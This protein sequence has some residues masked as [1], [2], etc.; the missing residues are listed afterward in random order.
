MT[1]P[2]RRMGGSCG[3]PLVPPQII[4]DIAQVR[5]YGCEKYGDPD[6][7]RRVEKGRYLDA[8]L[9]HTLAYL[10]DPKG[11]DTES[12]LPHYKHMA[13][14]MAFLCEMEKEET[15]MASCKI[16]GNKEP[17]MYCVC[18]GCMDKLRPQWISVKERLPE[19]G[20]PVV[21]AW[22]DYMDIAQYWHGTLCPHW[23]TQ[24]WGTIDL[25]TVT[26]WM[27]LPEPPED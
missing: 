17:V 27:P 18:A 9:R 8:L 20:V 5:M 11:L 25:I 1:R 15:Q 22:D 16:C 26:H 6:N 23:R 10:E 4:R 14:N 19:F 12:G 13:C 7:W 24:H 21:I 3:S 2:S